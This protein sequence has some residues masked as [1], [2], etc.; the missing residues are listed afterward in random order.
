LACRPRGAVNTSTPQVFKAL[1]ESLPPLAISSA[2]GSDI[3]I[4][5][6]P[7][8]SDIGK[9][10]NRQDLETHRQLVTQLLAAFPSKAPTESSLVAGLVALDDFYRSRLSKSTT[11]KG[12][13]MWAAVDAGSIRYLITYIFTL[14]RTQRGSTSSR[15]P[16]IAEMKALVQTS[17]VHRKSL[18]ADC[19]AD[20]CLT[21]A[22]RLWL[23]NIAFAV[24]AY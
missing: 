16:V 9:S 23:L 15:C 2:V 21:N 6:V 4:N 14:V 19:E 10:P 3:A 1:R 20:A 13:R 12:K 17:S 11:K 18:A 5:L 24:A 22:A 8:T 7:L